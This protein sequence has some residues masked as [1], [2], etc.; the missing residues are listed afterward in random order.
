MIRRFL[1]G[2]TIPGALFAFSGCDVDVKDSGAPPK[3]DVDVEEGRA[4]DVDVHPPDVDVG[5]ERR[6]VDVPVD[7]DVQTEKRE[8]E[9][10]DVDIN[11]PDENE[12]E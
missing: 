4:P 6:E 2:L 5:T 7:V 9:V 1:A 8:V 3:M 11:V 12:N 10:P